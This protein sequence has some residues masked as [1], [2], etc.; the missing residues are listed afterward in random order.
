MRDAGKFQAV[1]DILTSVSLVLTTLPAASTSKSEHLGRFSA[2]PFLSVLLNV[3]NDNFNSILLPLMTLSASSRTLTGLTYVNARKGLNNCGL[4][5]AVTGEKI[6]TLVLV[7]S[8][9][10]NRWDNSEGPQRT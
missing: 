10:S 5:I 1:M 3:I 4:V 7:S 9:L 2:A 8:T 6:T